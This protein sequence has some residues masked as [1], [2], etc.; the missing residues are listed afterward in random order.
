MPRRGC[1]LYPNFPNP[2]NSIT[3]IRFSVSASS[4]ATLRI[5]DLSG[6]KIAELADQTVMPGMHEVEFNGEKLPSGVY[7]AQLKASGLVLQRKIVLAE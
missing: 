3:K 6:R 2:F 7:V 4:H 5:F 1:F